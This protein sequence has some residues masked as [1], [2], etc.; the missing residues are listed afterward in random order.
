MNLPNQLNEAET[1]YTLIDPQLEKAGWNLADRRSVGFEIPVDGYAAAPVNGITDYCL[2]R[3]NGEILAVIEAKKTRRDARV[4]KEQ[5]LQYLS[6]IEKKQSFRPFGFL[7]NGDDISFWYSL[8]YPDGPVAGFYTK[9]DLDR[10]LFSEDFSR[11]ITEIRADIARL[12]L[13]SFTSNKIELLRL[14]L[15]PLLRFAATGSLAETF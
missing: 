14:K 4:G 15:A 5:L 11:T 13:N 1:R 6:K 2:Y 10:L 8:E 3:D 7:T 12:P 9:N